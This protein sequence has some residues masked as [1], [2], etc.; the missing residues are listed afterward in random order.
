MS[1]G[2]AFVFDEFSFGNVSWVLEDG[3]TTW[4]RDRGDAHMEIAGCYKMEAIHM[5]KACGN[6][7]DSKSVL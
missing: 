6:S 7:P 2:I 4:S 1:L 5:L 3:E